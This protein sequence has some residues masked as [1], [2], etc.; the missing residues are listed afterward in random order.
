MG[1]PPNGSVAAMALDSSVNVLSVIFGQIYFPT[2]SNGLKEI[3]GW[4]GFVWS[5]RMVGEGR[6]W[7]AVDH[8]AGRVGTVQ[9]TIDERKTP[10]V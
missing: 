8:L 6:L 1:G 3:A 5:I 10:F 4:L 9:R 7:V 2:Y